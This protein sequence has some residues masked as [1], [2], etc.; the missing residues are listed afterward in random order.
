METLRN[1]LSINP[2]TAIGP[3]VEGLTPIYLVRWRK[4][5]DVPDV[6]DAIL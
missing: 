3:V 6:A 2:E 5:R 1:R 4:V